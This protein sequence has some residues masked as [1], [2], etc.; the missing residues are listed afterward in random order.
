MI[1]IDAH[2]RS[3]SVFVHI[4]STFEKGVEWILKHGDNWCDE[5]YCFF[6][7]EVSVDKDEYF[8][9]KMDNA[10]YIDLKGNML[11]DNPLYSY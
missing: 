9:E 5:D 1:K 3:Y 4:A 7:C 10:F 8:D 11:K 2:T 6:A